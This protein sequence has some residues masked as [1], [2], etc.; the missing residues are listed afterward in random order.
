M[1]GFETAP[2]VFESFAAP[3]VERRKVR[4][5]RWRLRRWTLVCACTVVAAALVFQAALIA[6]HSHSKAGA[7]LGVI[8]LAG[9]SAPDIADPSEP[10]AATYPVPQMNGLLGN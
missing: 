10:P 1:A 8:T 2:L 6:K 4:V 3:R 7:P 9:P 5:P